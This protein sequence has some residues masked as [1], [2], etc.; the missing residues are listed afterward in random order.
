MKGKTL[1]QLRTWDIGIDT[2]IAVEVIII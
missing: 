1:N 2:I